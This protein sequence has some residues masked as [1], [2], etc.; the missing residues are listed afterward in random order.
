MT[1]HGCLSWTASTF[2]LLGNF[3]DGL[4][5]VD[6]LGVSVVSGVLGLGRSSLVY[7]ALVHFFVVFVAVQLVEVGVALQGFAKAENA[8]NFIRS[9]KIFDKDTLEKKFRRSRRKILWSRDKNLV[10][11]T[12]LL[13]SQRKSKRIFSSFSQG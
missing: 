12:S 13:L 10:T 7:H 1:R 2:T 8:E 9:I 5:E 11:I 3:P 6:V 4:F